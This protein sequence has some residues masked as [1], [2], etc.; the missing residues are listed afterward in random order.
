MYRVMTTA[1]P[2]EEQK[3]SQ[4][5]KT[6]KALVFHGPNQI[7]VEAMAISK[8]GHGEAVLR[9]T[10]TIICGTD[11]HI[12]RG[13]YPV[14]PG[15]IVGHEA[16]GVIHELGPGV[17]GYKV[18]DRVL[19]GAITP[20]GQC[21]SCLNGSWS[22]CG[23]GRLGGWQHDPWRAGGVLTCASGASQYGKDS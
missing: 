3:T 19:V 23:G 21:S 22:Q 6:M 8:A 13:E 18:E 17:T 9:I 1:I 15:L 14:K 16:V 11:V 5:A 2:S 7:A 12:L 4:A 10:L 20:C